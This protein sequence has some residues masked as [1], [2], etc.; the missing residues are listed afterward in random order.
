[1][2]KLLFFG[3]ILAICILAMPQGVLAATSAPTV[4]IEATYLGTPLSFVAEKDLTESGSWSWPL[5]VNNHN[6]K[7]PA[8]RFIVGTSSEWDVVATATDG[9][10]MRGS[11]G[12]LKQPIEMEVNNDNAAHAIGSGLTVLNGYGPVA[13]GT[14]YYSDL[15]Q[16]VNDDDYGAASGYAITLTFTC[17][18]GV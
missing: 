2:K 13:S 18:S 16:Q 14:H 17:T 1:M 7:S 5:S 11:L 10:F 9:G 4:P 8:L 3:L 15:W 6:L 12:L